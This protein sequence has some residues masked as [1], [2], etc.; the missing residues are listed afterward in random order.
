MNPNEIKL[1]E[2]RRLRDK[3]NR[4]P[5]VDDPQLLAIRKEIQLLRDYIAAEK[6]ERKAPKKKSMFDSINADKY[7]WANADVRF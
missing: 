2:L 5:Y 1:Y 4:P 6:K 3:L 7:F